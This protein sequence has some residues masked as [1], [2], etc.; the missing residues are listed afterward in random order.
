MQPGEG[1]MERVGEIIHKARLMQEKE[2]EVLAAETLMVESLA[3]EMA[4]FLGSPAIGEMPI[5][6]TT[7]IIGKNKFGL[8]KYEKIYVFRESEIM[9][10]YTWQPLGWDKMGHLY[11]CE[12]NIRGNFILSPGV[13]PQV[14]GSKHYG[15][16]S[17]VESVRLGDAVAKFEGAVRRC[18]QI[19]KNYAEQLEERLAKAQRGRE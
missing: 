4:A 5:K 1:L 3:L 2:E 9:A 16:G 15:F 14:L 8:K 18:R 17:G 7:G 6:E 11:Y 13:V 19:H 12:D 10:R